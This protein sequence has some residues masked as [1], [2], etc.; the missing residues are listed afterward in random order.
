LSL[1]RILGWICSPVAWILGIPWKDAQAVGMLLGKKIVLNEFLAYGDLVHLKDQLSPR[2][3]AMATYALCGFANFGSV[4]IQ[5]GGI[6]NLVPS[7][8]EVFARY[9]LRA[10]IG[11][12]LTTFMTAAIAGVLLP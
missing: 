9:G 6:G 8:R 4:A 3:F 12:V 11:G 7:R 10:M 2:S 1:E 5:I